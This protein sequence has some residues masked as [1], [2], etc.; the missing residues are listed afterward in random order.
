ML[1]LSEHSHRKTVV[2]IEHTSPGPNPD[3]VDGVMQHVSRGNV[4]ILVLADNDPDLVQIQTQASEVGHFV[5]VVPACE[6][7]SAGICKALNIEAD[8]NGKR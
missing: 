3:R 2:S 5:K 1:H 8:R 6:L 7:N 4:D